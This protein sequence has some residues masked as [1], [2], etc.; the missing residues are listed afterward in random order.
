MAMVK[1][2][3]YG[4]GSYEIA[5]TLQFHRVDY[6]AVAYAD[7]GVELRKAGITLPIMVMSPEVQAFEDIVN[8]N[9]EPEIFSFR[10]LHLFD[11]YLKQNSVTG[12]PVHL[13]LDTGMHRLGFEEAD[14]EKLVGETRKN[15]RIKITSVF[16]HLAATDEESMDD[17]TREQ[18]AAF[19][20]TSKKIT[21]ALSYPVLLHICNSGG[22]A[23]FPEAH[24]DMVRLGIGMYGVAV[25]ETEQKQLV[26]VGTLKTTISQIK[27]LNAG[28][29]VGYSRKGK[30]TKPTTIATV[31]I[32]YADGLSRKLSNGNGYMYIKGRAVPLIGNVCMDMCMLDITG[33][34]CREGDEVIIFDSIEKLNAISQK[35]ETIPYEVLTSVSTRVKRIYVQE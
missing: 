14:T 30:I 24:F 25:N 17:F 10:V 8:Y 2:S 13:K 34:E 9:L 31:P 22:I 4:S 12:Y 28:D 27:H 21:D 5:S 23:R 3:S 33:I 16:S 6:L 15:D 35:A 1:A 11:E 32:G 29:T 20:K 26:N 7:E 18:I 19:K